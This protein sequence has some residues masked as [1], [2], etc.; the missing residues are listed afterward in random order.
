MTLIGR[1]VKP[2]DRCHSA[3]YHTNLS[4]GIAVKC[5][6]AVQKMLATMPKSVFW[7]WMQLIIF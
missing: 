6:S 5:R 2:R 3:E 4:T 1:G 7:P